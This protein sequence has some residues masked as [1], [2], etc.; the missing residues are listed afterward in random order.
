VRAIAEKYGVSVPQL[1]IRYT[2]QLGCVS[3]PKT[4]NPEHMRAN[5]QVDFVISGA[6][7]EALRRLDD[8]DYGAHA[9]FPVYS[10]G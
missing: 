9:A 7:M 10:G 5:A 2:L 6:D 4:A 3:L 1:C 8:R